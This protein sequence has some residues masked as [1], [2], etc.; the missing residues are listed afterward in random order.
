MSKKVGKIDEIVFERIFSRLRIQKRS[1]GYDFFRMTQRAKKETDEIIKILERKEKKYQKLRKISESEPIKLGEYFNIPSELQIDYTI[2]AKYQSYIFYLFKDILYAVKGPHTDE[3][4]K[5]LIQWEYDNE[6]RF[7]KEL[8]HKYDEAGTKEALKKREPI[9][10]KVKMAVWRRDGGKCVKCGGR[11]KLEF[12][13]IIPLS[14]EGSNTVRNIEL[15]CE[16][17]NRTKGDKI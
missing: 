8:S 11:E 4:F 2:K 12:D 13:H 7:F 9:S 3:E 1:A 5:L 14:K 16:K 17:C 15:L 10:E 6:R